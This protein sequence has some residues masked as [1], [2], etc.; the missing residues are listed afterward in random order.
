MPAHGDLTLALRLKQF[1]ENLLCVFTVVIGIEFDSD[2]T[3]VREF[4]ADDA[5]KA[6]C[7]GLK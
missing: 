6:I 5:R 7:R 3:K 1:V 4:G 2:A